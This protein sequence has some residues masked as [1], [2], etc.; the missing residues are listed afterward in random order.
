[1]M[2]SFP[3]YHKINS[4]QKRYLDGPHKGKFTGEWA[5]PEFEYLKDCEWTWTEKIDGTNIRIGFDGCA[6]TLDGNNPFVFAGRRGV[7]QLQGNLAAHLTWLTDRL[8]HHPDLYDVLTD[9]CVLYGEGFGGNI[10]GK[11]EVYGDEQRFVLF[12][13]RSGDYWF[14]RAKVEEIATALGIP[15]VPRVFLGWSLEQAVDFVSH[16]H[17]HS[18]YNPEFEAEGVVGVPAVPLYTRRGDRIVVKVKGCDFPP[19]EGV[20]VPGLADPT[21]ESA[22]REQR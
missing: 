6:Y 7:S 11:S 1:M 15:V 20:T 22:G 8:L 3:E 21:A 19:R 4:L 16:H 14:E 2:E 17:F 13:I 9:E 10:A 12:D 18:R 5:R